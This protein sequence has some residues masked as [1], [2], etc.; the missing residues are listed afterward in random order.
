MLVQIRDR[1]A[2]SSLPST[3]LR[4]YL[5][6]H[7]WKDAGQW[8]KRATIH[9][10][11]YGRRNWEI[12]IPLSDTVADYAERMAESIATL[13]T[14][15][16]RSQIDVFYDVSKAGPVEVQELIKDISGVET[17]ISNPG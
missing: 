4:H 2:L 9:Q 6:T 5:K 16:K 8:G 14:V 3:N 11:K 7:G 12:L 13:A 10:K 15:E 17:H 1:A